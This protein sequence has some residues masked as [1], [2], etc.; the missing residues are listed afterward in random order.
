MINHIDLSSVLRQAV[1]DLYSDLV[2]RPTGAAVREQIEQLLSESRERTLTV[3]DFTHV[4]LLD[5]SCAD[6]VVAKLL[7]RYVADAPPSD[8]YFVL[9]G[10]SESHL[11]ALEAVLERHGLALVVE[12]GHDAH[13]IGCVDERERSAWET[14]VRLGRGGA[15]DL[16]MQLGAGPADA[17]RVLDTLRRRRLVMRMDDGYSAVRAVQ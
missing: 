12:T 1:C 16:A 13:V 9:R 15:A 17:E 3:I 10:V 4:G 8:A 11:D 5:F 2:T 7:L 6:E 14:L